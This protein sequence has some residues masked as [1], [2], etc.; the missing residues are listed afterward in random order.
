VLSCLL[1]ADEEQAM[2]T[3]SGQG[4]LNDNRVTVAQLHMDLIAIAFACD[5]VRSATLKNGDGNDGTE[6]TIDGERLPNF[7]MIS[8][9]IYSHGSEGDPIVGAVDMHHKI[10]RLHLQMFKHLLDKMDGYGILDQ[11]L[12][13]FTNDLGTP[14]HAYR[15]VPFVIVGAGDGLLAQGQ[16]VDVGGVTHNKLLNTLITASGIRTGTG[17]YIEDFG[18]PEL[19]GGVLSEMLA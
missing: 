11:S 19:E 17:G 13:V 14:N 5:H 16:Y 4:T 12:A 9:R 3:M 8:H 1:T 18:D 15:D 10:D 6:Y 2:A 7:H